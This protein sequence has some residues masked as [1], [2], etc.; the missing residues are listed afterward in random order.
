MGWIEEE[1]AVRMSYC[2]RGVGRE[3]EEK[4]GR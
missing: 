2:E 4:V 1:K 3:K